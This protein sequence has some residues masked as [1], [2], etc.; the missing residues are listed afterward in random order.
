MG[1]QDAVV[2]QKQQKSRNGPSGRRNQTNIALP[3]N[4]QHQHVHV[5]A[6][7]RGRGS[8]HVGESERSGPFTFSYLNGTAI[9]V[10]SDDRT[11]VLPRA[12]QLHARRRRSSNLQV[13]STPTNLNPGTLYDG[14]EPSAGFPNAKPSQP[15]SVSAAAS[16]TGRTGDMKS[17]VVN[18]TSSPT[19]LAQA[20]CLVVPA[21]LRETTLSYPT[22]SEEGNDNPSD[23]ED[24]DVDL[25]DPNCARVLNRLR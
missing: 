24:G 8:V 4:S 23:A 17:A 15:R 9:H 25:E 11:R 13:A 10:A 1:R 16:P 5:G 3:D 19:L 14:W 22:M 20:S 12:E 7:R 21:L 6:I 2:K 18:L